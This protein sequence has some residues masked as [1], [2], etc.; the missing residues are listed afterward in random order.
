MNIC[1]PSCLLSNASSF[2]LV[3]D[4]PFEMCSAA[5][6]S[7]GRVVVECYKQMDL[8]WVLWQHEFKKAERPVKVSQ[9]RPTNVLFCVLASLVN[10]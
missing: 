3:L 7:P 4:L 1:N 10:L 6:Y 5:T 8:H 9:L 2:R